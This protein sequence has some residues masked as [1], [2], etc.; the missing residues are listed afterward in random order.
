MMIFSP[1]INLWQWLKDTA[2][3]K[4]Y[5]NIQ[6]NVY[7]IQQYFQ[8]PMTFRRTKPLSRLLYHNPA[9]SMKGN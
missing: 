9:I 1:Y 6:L 2:I 5:Q 4:L 7:Y 8:L 3:E